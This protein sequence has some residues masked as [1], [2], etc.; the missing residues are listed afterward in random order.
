MNLSKNIKLK[1][2]T[3][4]FIFSSGII[5]GIYYL[6]I[7]GESMKTLISLF[8]L[9]LL[10]NLKI[11][12]QRNTGGNKNPPRDRI[13]KINVENPVRNPNPH[14][15]PIQEPQRKKEQQLIVTYN[16]EPK[17]H[18]PI[19]NPHSP[20][21]Y[22][23]PPP[24]RPIYY[25]PLPPIID[26]EPNLEE[27]SLSEILEL[28]VF[29]LDS[30]EYSEAIKCFNHLLKNDPLDYEVLTLRGRA[31]HGLELFDRAKKDFQKSIKIEKSYADAYYYLG[32]TEIEFGDVD[33]AKVDFEIAAEF[34]HEKAKQLTKKYFS[35]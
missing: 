14:R 30:E 29:H 16:P 13:D 15:E 8:V 12:A 19:C 20:R 3:T 34:G 21:P 24:E 27:L 26:N 10:F 33:A 7:P 17:I 18:Q 4:F 9:I 22:D 2:E 5:I 11:T 31:Y 6:I 25:P 28:G 23:G 32:L 1:I 35:Q